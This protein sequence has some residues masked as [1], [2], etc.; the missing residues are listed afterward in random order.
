MDVVYPRCCGLDVHKATVTA[1]LLTPGQQGGPAKEL[2]TFRTM[3]GDLLA[4]SDWLLAAGCTHVA[5]E[6]TGVYWKPI[7]N[8]LEGAF[9]L[10]LV[11]AQHIKAVPG[12]KTDVRDSEWLAELLRHGL[13]RGSFVPEREQRE[14][15]EL[16]RYRTS[17]VRERASEVNRVHK[18]LEG[19]NIKLAS[20]ASDVMG[21]SGRRML[22]ELIGGATEAPALADLALGKLRAKL[23]ELEQ[24]LTG[25]VG[26]HQRFLLA[27]QLAHIDFLDELIAEVSTE[28]ARRMRPF[29]QALADLDS[30]PGVGRQ[31]AEVLVAEIGL[32]MARFPSPGHL[33]SWAGMCPGQHES[34][35]KR[36]SG[37]TRKGSPWLRATL[38]EAAHAAARKKQ[39]YLAA[40]YRRFAARRGKKTAAVAVG[41]TIL[42][43]AYHVLKRHQPYQDLGP[44]YFD[45]RDRQAIQ[46]RLTH[47]LESLGFEV[48]LTQRPPADQEQA[49]V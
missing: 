44:D 3:T 13:V 41:H 4:L 19:G 17:V 27:R 45:Q 42:V 6:S 29:E 49:A 39:C 46:R 25:R 28:V 22:A 16:V 47:R 12:R 26:G 30:I 8:L 37:R 18:A 2:R 11:N 36:R 14:V 20:V 32:D 5:L 33:A 35:G 38:V 21:T 1:C 24:A 7:W 10:L 23:P 40:Q 43:I 9:Q 15:R 48:R 34:A 31:T